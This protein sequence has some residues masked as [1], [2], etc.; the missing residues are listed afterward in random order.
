MLLRCN[1]RLFIALILVGC[2]SCS[3]EAKRKTET[4]VE[5]AVESFHQELNEEQ[6]QR[7]YAEA[8]GDLRSKVSEAEFT[9]QLQSAHEQLG[10]VSGKAFVFIDEGVWRGLRKALGRKREIVSHGNSPASDLIVGN[11]Q[12]V[13][14]VENDEPKL[15]SYRFQ[16]VC[17]KPCTVGFG[18]P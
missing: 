3:Y 1:A 8:D 4:A 9:A 14:A 13:W 12:F 5:R 15:V 2:S 10:R 7:I 11:E 17:S 16:R 6:Y 18:R